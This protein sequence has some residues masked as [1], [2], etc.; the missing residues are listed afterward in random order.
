[1]PI[2]ANNRVVDRAGDTEAAADSGTD[3]E[4]PDQEN[5]DSLSDLSSVYMG[6]NVPERAGPAEILPS[7]AVLVCCLS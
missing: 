3:A 6:L 4:V 7:H 1:M 2:I 5:D